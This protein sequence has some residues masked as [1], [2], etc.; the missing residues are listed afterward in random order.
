MGRRS[1]ICNK[2]FNIFQVWEEDQQTDLTILSEEHSSR[3]QDEPP[4]ILTQNSIFTKTSTTYC[5]TLIKGTKEHC[6]FISNLFLDPP[7]KY[8][9]NL[10]DEQSDV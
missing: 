8:E 7:P 2:W 5:P 3:P 6:N 9:F 4:I 10:D 1:N